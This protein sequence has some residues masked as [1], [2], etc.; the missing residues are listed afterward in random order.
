MTKAGD[1]HALPGLSCP[2]H[3][4]SHTIDGANNEVVA[5]LKLD[6]LTPVLEILALDGLNLLVQ[7]ERKLSMHNQMTPRIVFRC[8]LDFNLQHVSER[9]R[10]NMRRCW[11]LVA[12]SPIK[13]VQLMEHL[14]DFWTSK[15]ESWVV[16]CVEESNERLK[17]IILPKML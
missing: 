1:T 3:D 9:T 16:N 6:G 12:L 4:S 8:L 5:R 11:R 15:V 13:L 17:P 10:V 7:W 14:L 2:F